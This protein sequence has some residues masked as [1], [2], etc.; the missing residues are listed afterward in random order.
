MTVKEKDKD[1]DRQ[2]QKE[3]ERNGDGVDT[4]GKIKIGKKL[5]VTEIS[6]GDLPC[7]LTTPDPLYMYIRPKKHNV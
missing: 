2:R 7:S 3:R 5:D 1:K 4:N 6:T